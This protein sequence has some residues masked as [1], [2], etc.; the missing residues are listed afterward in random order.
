M[1]RF[2]IAFEY[3]GVVPPMALSYN[4]V[5]LHLNEATFMGSLPMFCIA[6]MLWSCHS[7][8]CAIL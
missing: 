1:E 7:H 3:A 8:L 5:V 4:T 2:Q 6:C